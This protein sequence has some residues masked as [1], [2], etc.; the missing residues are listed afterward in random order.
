M[1][2]HLPF[3]A[4]LLCVQPVFADID[5]VIGTDERVQIPSSNQSPLYNK[6]GLLLMSKKYACTGTLITPTIVLTAGHCVVD[7]TKKQL[8]KPSEFTF[9]P[10]MRK[11][12]EAPLGQYSVKRVVTFKQYLATNSFQHDVAIVELT[13]SPNL[14]TIAI[15]ESFNKKDLMTKK[16]TITGYPGDKAPG[17][18]WE[19]SSVGLNLMPSGNAVAHVADTFGGESGAAI[20]IVENGVVK[21]IG[22]HTGGA[23]N[24]NMGVAFTPE[25][26]AALKSWI[27]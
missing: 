19:S 20:R 21:I 15:R 7:A 1:I 13:K 12:S 23:E 2:K 6:I 9:Y 25:V 14:G 18:L 10:G 5:S 17:T 24:F 3:L 8:L 22:V 11:S 4:L 26:L 27:K 16:I